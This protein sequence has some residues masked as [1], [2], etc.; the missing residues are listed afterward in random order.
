MYIKINNQPKEVQDEIVEF[1]NRKGIPHE[2]FLS[3]YECFASE[4][5]DFYIRYIVTTEYE[6]HDDE[7]IDKVIA[8]CKDGLME[9]LM[10]DDTAIDT[11]Y[12][13]EIVSDNL[14][15]N[16]TKSWTLPVK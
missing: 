6:I 13:A 8:E 2:T 10:N 5:L 16:Y 7:K 15:Q 1:L 12:I 11:R 4:E 9:V 3:S 14:K